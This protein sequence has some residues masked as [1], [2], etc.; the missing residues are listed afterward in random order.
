M[1]ATAARVAGLGRVGG[2]IPLEV[3]PGTNNCTYGD[4][5]IGPSGQVMQACSLTE[6]GQGGGKIF[7]NVDP[8]G[9]GPAGFGDRIFVTE[10]HVGGFDFLPAPP[11]P[12]LDAE[13]CPACDRTA[14]PHAGR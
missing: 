14:T 8:D 9:L 3:V 10:T 4:V 11:D 13:V 5:A 7:V 6:S 1:A 2:F 12:S